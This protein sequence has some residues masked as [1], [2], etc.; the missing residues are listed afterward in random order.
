MRYISLIVKMWIYYFVICYENK[1]KAKIFKT[2]RY[3]YSFSELLQIFVR[4]RLKSTM[5]NSAYKIGVSIEDYISVNVQFTLALLATCFKQVS[6]L[7]YTL[8]M[9]DKCLSEISV[10]FQRTTRCYIPEAGTLQISQ[11]C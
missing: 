11:M 8:K 9:E 5:R 2:L 10:G 7:A 4:L 1:R 6:C 3:F